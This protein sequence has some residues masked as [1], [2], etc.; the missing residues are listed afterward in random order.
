ME[1]PGPQFPHPHPTLSPHRIDVDTG[2]AEWTA[3]MEMVALPD[4]FSMKPQHR[5]ATALIIA[6]CSVLPSCAT[7]RNLRGAGDKSPDAPAV[8]EVSQPEVTQKKSRF[9]WLPKLPKLP[10]LPEIL[11]SNMLP[12]NRVKVVDV[13]EKDLRELPTGRERALAFKEERKQGFWIFDGPLYFE[14]PTLPN[15]GSETDEGLLPPLDP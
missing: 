10:K 1:P 8:A 7:I 4:R 3:P 15:A 11:G 5:V 14:E 9:A 2:I 13:R 12:G 6:A